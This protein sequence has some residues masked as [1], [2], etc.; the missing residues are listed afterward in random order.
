[1]PMPG[2]LWSRAREVQLLTAAAGDHRHVPPADLL[3]AATVELANARLV[4]YD[5]DYDQIAAVTAQQHW[6][7]VPDGAL[8]EDESTSARPERAPPLPCAQLVLRGRKRGTVE[9]GGG[10]RLGVLVE[11][12]LDESLNLRWVRG[13]YERSWRTRPRHP[14]RPG[15]CLPA[16]CCCRARPRTR[17]C[18]RGRPRR[19]TSCANRSTGSRRARVRTSRSAQRTARRAR[20]RR[21]RRAAPGRE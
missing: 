5:R 18:A 11:M 19:C 3:I 16:H 2:S 20:R 8:A 14:R 12:H 1:M 7:F 17:S 21:G 9:E 10:D 13:R 4:H 6:W 15:P